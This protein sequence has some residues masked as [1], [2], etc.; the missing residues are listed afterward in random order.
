MLGIIAYLI[1][2]VLE[3]TANGESL[4]FRIWGGIGI[5]LAVMV[6]ISLF[7]P[8]KKK[9]S[10]R[11]TVR[12]GRSSGK[13]ETVYTYLSVYFLNRGNWY[14]YLT[15]DPSVRPNDVVVV[16]WGKN[17][18]PE[19]AIVGWVEQRLASDVPYPLSR[20]KYMIRKAS[21]K[22]RAAFDEMVRWP[23]EVNV[24]CRWTRDEEGNGFEVVNEEEERAKLRRWI[25]QN[26][27]LKAVE[28]MVIGHET[29]SEKFMNAVKWYNIANADW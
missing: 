2:L 4:F 3:Y 5:F 26:P 20:T 6:V 12:C 23:M 22:S 19:L 7:V 10:V 29:E 24:S 17:N 1:V 21:D 18:N 16:P 27:R 8:E 11:D 15:K 28:R 14:Y 25:G 13:P 9:V